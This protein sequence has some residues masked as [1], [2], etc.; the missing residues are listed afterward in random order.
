MKNKKKEII[1]WIILTI[2]FLMIIFITY[3]RFFGIYDYQNKSHITNVEISSNDAIDTA[4]TAIV[5]NINNDEDL[6]VLEKDE[7]KLQSFLK[8]HSLYISY[9]DLYNITTTYEFNY[10]HLNLN[11]NIKNNEENV[12]KFNIIYKFLLKAIQKRIN[13]D[14]NKPELIDSHINDGVELRGITKTIINNEKTIS[15]KID[16]TKK[17]DKK[18]GSE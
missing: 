13:S 7:I 12:K 5:N 3:M 8:N 16:I 15:Y 6:K 2:L 18:E 10:S 14:F 9:T 1:A 4:L 11:I 17:L